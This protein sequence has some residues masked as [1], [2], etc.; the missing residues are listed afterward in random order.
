[1]LIYGYFIQYYCW[2]WKFTDVTYCLSDIIYWICSGSWYHSI[3]LILMAR[4]TPPVYYTLLERI[5]PLLPITTTQWVAMIC[6]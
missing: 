4:A 5:E 1:M 2:I 3:K 6:P